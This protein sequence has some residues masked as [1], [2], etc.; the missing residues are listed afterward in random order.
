M[1]LFCVGAM[2]SDYATQSERQQSA[3]FRVV[4]Q[5]SST[6]QPR[7][8]RLSEVVAQIVAIEFLAVGLSAYTASLAYHYIV[9]N[10]SPPA[11]QYV[12]AAVFIALMVSLSSISF[13]QFSAIQTQPRHRFLWSGIAAVGLAFSLFLSTLFLFKISEGY[14]RGSFVF[15]I[16]SVLITVT[17]TR[18]AIYSWLQST[19]AAGRLMARRVVLIGED[20]V[21]S[22]FADRL[23][24]TGILSVASFEFPSE[25]E[26]TQHGSGLKTGRSI[27]ATLDL[28]RKKHPD[29][30]IIIA[31]QEN[32]STIPSLLNK[33]SELPINVHIVPHDSMYLLATS[34]IAEFGNVTTFQVSSTPLSSFDRN[35]KRVFDIAAAIAGLV[36]FSPL[37]LCTAAA[38]KLDSHGPVLFR[39]TRHGYNKQTIKV[40]KFRTMTTLEDGSDFR[41]VRRNDD[42]ITAVGRILRRTNIDE[43]PQLINVLTGQMSIVGPR[44][45]ATAHNDMFEGRILPFAR[46]HN[47]RP[48][49]TG[50]AQVNGARGETDTVEKMQERINY[51][52]YY[53]DNWSLF[54]DLKIIVMTLFS[55]RS[56]TNAY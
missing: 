34:R 20:G 33:L 10:S 14:S 26:L 24:A 39:Q 41:Q 25:A 35:I 53:I 9:S 11:Y 52:L 3:I 19:I 50:W 32:S 22:Q 8:R 28:C 12:P 40:L 7:T 49:I 2:N 15:Q 1:L 56:Y 18:A 37:L 54:F 5:P 21:C 13:R 4:D 38:I 46:R 23:K 27:P 44:P 48:G 45:H 30:V 16:V 29:D 42:R 51:D 47:V 17:A 31:N 55:K 6:R 36:L 43:L